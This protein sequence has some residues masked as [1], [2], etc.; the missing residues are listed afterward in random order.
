MK[1]LFIGLGSIG[2][3]HLKNLS[4]LC[5]QKGI[6]LQV[7]ALRSSS[8]PLPP[9]AEALCH[10]Q[11]A[12]LPAGEAFDI[13]FVTNPTNLHAAALRELAGKAD[14]LFIEK[15]IF[16]GSGYSLEAL[17]LST[18]QKAY[19]AAPMRW[20]GVYL[21]LK[22]RL[23]GLPVYSVRSICSSYLPEWR[24]EA[25]YR[26]VYSAHKAMGG[27]VTLDLIHEWDY[28]ADL[29]GLPLQSFNLKGKFSHLEIDSDDLSVYIAAYPQFLCELHLDYFGRQ[30][31]RGVEIF[32]EAG[33]LSAD[34]GTGLLALP[35]GEVLDF[36]EPANRRYE[37]EMEYF[38]NYAQSGVGES[39]NSPARALQVLKLTLGEV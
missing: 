16:E 8:K 5:L 37:R 17:G 36:A 1:A 31:R 28:L 9:E 20:C 6:A 11:M 12:A 29:F 34:F 10:R 39:V 26:R 15:P 24:K 4:A 2:Q 21:A 7:T 19:V 22:A 23:A 27:G 30:Y 33:I 35:G 18:G 3:R 25:D 13:A 14:T 38:L 32:T